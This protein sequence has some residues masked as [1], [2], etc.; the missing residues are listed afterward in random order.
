MVETGHFALVLALALSLVQAALPFIGARTRQDRLMAVGGAGGDHRLRDDGA[1]LRLAL[2]AAYVQSD[3]SV[4]NVWSRTP[5]R[6]KPLLYK[7]TGTWGNHEGSMLLWVLILTFF[8]ALVAAF[9][10]NLP[11]I[12]QG[13]RDLGAGA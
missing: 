11:A 10:R 2:V 9:G 3:F 12:A 13:R 8:G 4:L 6:Q 7:I 5:I 1:V